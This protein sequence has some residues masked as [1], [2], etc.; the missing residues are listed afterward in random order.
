MRRT[1]AAAADALAPGGALA[2]TVERADDPSGC[3]LQ[4][5]RRYAHSRGHVEAAAR[6]AGLSVALLEE[7]APRRERGIPVPAF[8]FVLVRP[9]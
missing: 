4:P 5:N 1:F 3:V 2:A 6:A 7:A 9:G 8:V